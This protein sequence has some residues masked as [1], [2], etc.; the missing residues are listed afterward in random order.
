MATNRARYLGR[1][2]KVSPTNPT[3]GGVSGDPCLLG[4]R[5][6]VMLTDQASGAATVDFDGVYNLSVKGIDNS[7]NAAIAAGDIVYYD[8]ATTPKLSV[9]AVGTVRFGYALAA[10]S[11]GATTTIPV[12]I[13]Y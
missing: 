1:Q 7:G 13:G 4:Q 8:T 10:V 12:K 3:S 9:D 6:G 11:S 5:P 2:L